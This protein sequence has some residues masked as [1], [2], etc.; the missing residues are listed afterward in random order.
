MEFSIISFVNRKFTL[1]TRCFSETLKK[2]LSVVSLNKT[3]DFTAAYEY[4]KL[5]T[6]ALQLRIIVAVSLYC[7]SNINQTDAHTKAS[8]GKWSHRGDFPDVVVSGVWVGSSP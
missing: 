1:T 6:S 8:M 3:T 5:N 7:I 2:F 4:G